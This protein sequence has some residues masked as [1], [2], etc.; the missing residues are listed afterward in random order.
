MK[1]AL[2]LALPL[3]AALAGCQTVDEAADRAA[4]PGDAAAR[5][6]PAR[7]HGAASRQRRAGQHLDRGGRHRAG[8]PRRAPAHDR[9]V[10]GAGLRLGRRPSQSGQ[11]PARHE[12]PAG[13]HLGDLPNVTIGSVGRGHGQR[14]ACR[15]RATRCWRGCSTATAPRSWSMRAPT[16]TAPIRRAIRAAGSPAAC[17]R[18]R[19][20]PARLS[21]ERRAIVPH[22]QR[23]RREPERDR[24]PG[25]RS[26]RARGCRSLPTRSRP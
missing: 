7:R 22:G 10:R 24:P 13:A 25:C 3:A 5:Q 11:P 26:R 12:N 18:G 17:S 9:F 16:T 2:A 15:D 20:A 1:R 14:D 21:R 23:Q 6:R 8:R 4:R 19:D